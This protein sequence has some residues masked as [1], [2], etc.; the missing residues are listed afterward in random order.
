MPDVEYVCF[1]FFKQKTAYEMRISDWSSDV[2]SSDLGLI[3]WALV[4]RLFAPAVLLLLVIIALP[5]LAPRE[6]GKRLAWGGIGAF[7]LLA[8][9]AGIVVVNAKD[10]GVQAAVPVARFAAVPEP[11]PMQ[12]GADWPAY[13]GTDGAQ[14]YSPLNQINR[15]IGR[16]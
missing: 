6:G 1:F 2:C 4:P 5:A 7:V 11:A 12:V 8:A 10:P 3:G 16:A 14:R 9:I 13:G 15:K